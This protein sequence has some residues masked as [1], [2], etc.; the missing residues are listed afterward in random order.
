MGAVMSREKRCGAQRPARVVAVCTS[1]RRADPK[2]DL[3]EGEL[4]A[5]YGLLGD[6]HAGFGERQVSLLALESIE[7]ANHEHGTS[8]GP[9]CFAENLTTCGLDLFS[10]QIGEQ[11]RVGRALLEVVQVG[12]PPE[13]A[14][15]YRFRGVSILPHEGVFCRVVEGGRVARAD[16]VEM[17]PRDGR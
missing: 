3:G 12:K 15:T 1:G 10:L 17:V 14:H 7:R 9:G 8:A 6:A 13:K 16:A 2:V 11:L 4:V 5:G